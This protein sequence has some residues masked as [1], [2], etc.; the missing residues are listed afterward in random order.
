MKSIYLFLL[1]WF[2]VSCGQSDETLQPNYFDEVEYMLNGDIQRTNNVRFALDE[3]PAARACGRTYYVLS[4]KNY[5]NKIKNRI[6]TYESLFFDKITLEPGKREL[7]ELGCNN[8]G[9]GVNFTSLFADDLIAGEYDLYGE[10]DEN[11]IEITDIDTAA[12]EIKGRFNLNFIVS[13]EHERNAIPDTV[14]IS[15]GAF[16]AKANLNSPGPCCKSSKGF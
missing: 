10:S 7:G 5:E 1:I 6:D 15:E 2:I 12:K 9:I 11:W 4:V 14:F 16:F 3:S 13:Y 8:P